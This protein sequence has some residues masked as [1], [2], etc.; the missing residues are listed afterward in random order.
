MEEEYWRHIEQG[1]R[2]AYS[3]TYILYY[4]K[5]YNYG[6]KFTT[7]IVLIEDAIQE[8]FLM[9]WARREK[10]ATIKSPAGYLFFSFRNGLF[11]KLKKAAKV[12][13]HSDE[14][15]AGMEFG[16]DYVIINREND[17]I[18]K[19]QLETAIKSL[20]SRQREAIF[21]RFYEGLSY[22]EVAEIMAISVKSTYKIMARAL[23]QL[24]DVLAIS[25]IVLLILIRGLSF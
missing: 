2:E 15:D 12:Q 21:L 7:D 19:Q 1:D 4:K 23:H 20:S 3:K 5:L 17:A 22:E 14:A 10:L 16:A 9:L 13:A 18:Q 24:K 25:M 8:T 11:S 6:R